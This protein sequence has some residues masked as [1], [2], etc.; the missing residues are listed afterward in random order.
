M[1]TL[2]AAML[3]ESGSG[4]PLLKAGV[5]RSACTSAT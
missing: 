5:E 3:S 4:S 1:P 2:T